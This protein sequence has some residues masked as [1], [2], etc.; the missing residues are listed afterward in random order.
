MPYAI[1][2][3]SKMKGGPAKSIEAHHERK[4]EKYFSN[5]D[6]KPSLKD[7]NYHIVKPARSYYYEIQSRIENAGC[8]TRKDSI[9]F[10]DTIVTASPEFL[11][12]LPQEKTREFFEKAFA[13]LS[14]EIGSENIFSAAVHMD[15]KTPHM[16]LCFVPLT[17][18]KR[19]SAKEIIGNRI[20]LVEWQDKFHDYMS[21]FYPTLQ[22]GE[23]AA[24][25]KRKHVPVRLFKQATNL[26]V[27]MEEIQGLMDNMN[28]INLSKKRDL[29]LKELSLWLPKVNSFE[30]QIK[31]VEKGNQDLKQ[32]ISALND[33]NY[34]LKDK[35]WNE[36][37]KLSAQESKFRKLAN[38]YRDLLDFCNSIPKDLRDDLFSKYRHVQNIKREKTGELEL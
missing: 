24:E 11:E 3:F 7:Q 9:R 33:E 8:K 1:L 4:K 25:T 13:F 5:P 36:G 23:P 6:I 30:K 29:L 37:L 34:D 17:K 21:E 35:N 27:K 32:T 10:V 26:T 31:Q 18:D 2:R 14:D 15:E 38:D 12:N 16:H 20:K 19:L 22:R 28:V